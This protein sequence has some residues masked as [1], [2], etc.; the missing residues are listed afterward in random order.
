M[1]NSKGNDRVIKNRFISLCLTLILIIC[2]VAPCL[3][4]CSGN[5]SADNGK[6]TVVATVFP[7]YDWAR[8]ILDEKAE[9]TLL[10]SNGT[11]LHSYEPTAEDIS[12]IATCD[13]LIYVGGESDKWAE[14]VLKT[15]AKKD[16]VAVNLLEV[17]GDAVVE[18]EALE[19][20]EPT[21]EDEDKPEADEHVWLSLKNAQ[22]VCTYIAET[23]G[24]I[25]GENAPLYTG[26]ANKYN[27]KL[28][29]LDA[30]YKEA[31]KTARYDTLLFADRFPFR[32]LADDL[33][34]T[35][36]AAFSGCSAEIEAGAETI[37]FLSE[38]LNELNLP[39]VMIIDGSK[40]NIASTVIKTAKGTQKILTLNSMQSV[41]QE[42][43]SKGVT[44]L[45]VMESNLEILKEAL[46]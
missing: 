10:T 28:D 43:I 39:A 18:E 16:I 45:S 40:V 38:K 42:D 6:L 5:E 33:G 14:D 29:N 25:D 9:I 27:E 41:T 2:L 22:T 36:Y 34:L 19:G 7:A 12:K 32:Y 8:E 35:C 44:Y 13:M 15:S 31:V 1:Q 3:S 11:D 26:N 46:N 30:K 37:A 4:G 17:L 24:E 20:M 21:H 23:L